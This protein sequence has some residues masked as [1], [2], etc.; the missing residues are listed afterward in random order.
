MD[1]LWGA[2]TSIATLSL[3]ESRILDYDIKMKPTKQDKEN[4]WN[5]PNFFTLSRI[6]ISFITIY[7]IFADF[8]I[9]Y[10]IVAFIIGM[11]TDA[12]D[13]QIARRFGL[14][15]EFGSKFD[16]I[17]DRFLMIPVALAAVIKFSIE[18]IITRGQVSQIFLILSREIITLPFLLMTGIFG[19]T[20]SVPQV[21]FIGKAVTVMQ[22][23]TFPM[24]LL[25]IFYKV[26][27]IS[28]YFALATGLIGLVSGFYYIYDTKNLLVKRKK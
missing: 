10:V 12:V 14:V 25:S 8:H 3:L 6:I 18:E 19:K 15:T 28:L 26:F 23:I 27:G 13:G 4:I 20:I 16:M 24:I 17:A 7:F 22:A 11:L 1:I 21:R 5:L 2:R 9:V